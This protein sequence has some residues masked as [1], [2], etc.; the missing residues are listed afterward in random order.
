M[1]MRR[2]F[3]VP[4]QRA[5]RARAAGRCECHLVPN[6]DKY[7]CH[8]LPLQTGRMIYEHVDPWIFSH[9]SSLAN[10]A[11]LRI[12][13]ARAKTDLIDAG[14]IAKSDRVRDAHTGIKDPWRHKLPC[15]RDSGMTKPMRGRPRRRVPVSARIRALRERRADAFL[16][17]EADLT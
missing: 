2:D 9:D 6:F 15:G 5:M 13:C 11:L 3:S 14:D 10:G 12:E 4:I 1:T 17:E 8:G 7:C 16:S